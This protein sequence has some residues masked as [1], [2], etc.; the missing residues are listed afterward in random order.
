MKCLL[1]EKKR[2]FPQ[3]TGTLLVLLSI[4]LVLNLI[5]KR[6]L[7]SILRSHSL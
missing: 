7:V 2:L 6:L 5:L 4:F 3:K 1:K